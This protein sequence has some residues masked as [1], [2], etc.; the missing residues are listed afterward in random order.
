M[1]GTWTRLPVSATL[2]N[3][4]ETST[5]TPPEQSDIQT[6]T[7]TST[8]LSSTGGIHTLP[9]TST[10][11]SVDTDSQF[12]KG[13]T[14]TSTPFMTTDTF[15][16]PS[17]F[18]ASTP[19][20]KPRAD[21]NFTDQQEFGG[22][23][24]IASSVVTA[25]V[26]E[27]ITENGAS[28][29]TQASFS[30]YDKFKLGLIITLSIVIGCFAI[31]A[32]SLRIRSRIKKR[33]LELEI[34]KKKRKNAAGNGDSKPP[35]KRVT[36]KMCTDSN[37][38]TRRTNKR[39]LRRSHSPSL[40]SRAKIPEIPIGKD[41]DRNRTLDALL[42]AGTYIPIA[43]PPLGMA[44][45]RTKSDVSS[46]TGL[47]MGGKS[48]DAEEH[49]YDNPVI[50]SAEEMTTEVSMLSEETCPPLR[51][52]IDAEVHRSNL[53][54]MTHNASDSEDGSVEKGNFIE[55]S[56]TESL[57]DARRRFK[58][59]HYFGMRSSQRNDSKDSGYVESFI[60]Q[61][62]LRL[63]AMASLEEGRA[64]ADGMS[65]AAGHERM[66]PRLGSIEPT[67]FMAS[68]DET[69]NLNLNRSGSVAS[70][71]D[72]LP[73]PK[74]C[75]NN[76][77]NMR[78]SRYS[79]P[80]FPTQ[81]PQCFPHHRQPNRNPYHDMYGAPYGM[82]YQAITPRYPSS[83][84]SAYDY[85]STQSDFGPAPRR[86]SYVNRILPKSLS[87]ETTMYKSCDLISPQHKTGIQDY[88]HQKR[89]KRFVKHRSLGTQTGDSDN[90]KPMVR[91]DYDNAGSLV[92][93]PRENAG[94][95]F[96]GP[97]YMAEE[98]EEMGPHKTQCVI[99][100]ETATS[101]TSL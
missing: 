7:T 44:R 69:S 36:I 5:P 11:P 54:A 59:N 95:D 97:I 87:C 84:C 21:D 66:L 99:D 81:Y 89:V 18:P 63:R 30:P 38:S 16:D 91:W 25:T 34:V 28:T 58:L 39:P 17:D 29:T 6:V 37:S 74:V 80:S 86:N 43:P 50:S 10:A 67:L 77:M 78:Q 12:D 90:V 40:Q 52:K 27:I 51:M 49:A 4:L 26:S 32:I 2:A 65:V 3:D 75:R 93:K 88:A 85:A 72:G 35:V 98:L 33:R 15:Q 82:P 19:L 83:E 41:M 96:I 100:M 20:Y 79:V 92:A 71:N 22:S 14:D 31:T 60:S 53:D 47:I 13:W 57:S 55:S 1:A 61:D 42:D 56:E 23:S 48:C 73:H 45:D 70:D 101:T 94:I 8:L 46:R 64:L 76:I 68:V 62:S 9:P 24:I